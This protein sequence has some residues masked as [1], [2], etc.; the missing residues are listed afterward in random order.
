MAAQHPALITT[1]SPYA[2]HYPLYDDEGMKM[3][4]EETHQ[5][6]DAYLHHLW[7][8]KAWDPY[9]SKLTPEL[10]RSK[11]TTYNLIARKYL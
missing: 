5:F 6:V 9:L 10:I 2:F 11:D 7:E 3:L 8:S 1:L 4:F